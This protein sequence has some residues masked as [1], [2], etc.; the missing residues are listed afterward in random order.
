MLSKKAA[1][2]WPARAWKSRQWK[3]V[4]ALAKLTALHFPPPAGEEPPTACIVGHAKINERTTCCFGLL[5]SADTNIILKHHLFC[6]LNR[7]I[8]TDFLILS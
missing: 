3:L 7:N 6:L 8:T 5:S 2:T 1:S 4:C